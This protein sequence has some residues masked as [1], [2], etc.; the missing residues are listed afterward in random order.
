MKEIISLFI[1]MKVTSLI[2]PSFQPVLHIT[3]WFSKFN[4]HKNYLGMSTDMIIARHHPRE[5]SHEYLRVEPICL[6]NLEKHWNSKE[7]ISD[8]DTSVLSGDE[9]K[10]EHFSG[11]PQ[12]TSASLGVCAHFWLLDCLYP[13]EHTWA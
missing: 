9:Q 8:G 5:T 11:L 3:Q 6:H 13:E 4:E 2:G 12:I 7:G 10:S 1:H